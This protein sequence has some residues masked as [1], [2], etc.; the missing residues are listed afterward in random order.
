MN[1]PLIPASEEVAAK[2]HADRLL[3]TAF[4]D[5]S[6]LPRHGAAPPVPQPGRPPMSQGATDASAL[7][8]S[9]SV[10]TA[11][12]GGSATAILWASGHADPAVVATVF[13]APAIFALA[14]ARVL[15]RAKD[16]APDQHHHHY[17]GP[18]Y[19]DQRTQQ[20]STRGLIA[21]THNTQ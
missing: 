7:M 9:G 8:L 19:Q 2:E 18:V 3:A 4:R 10:L 11:T 16:A 15:K 5:D 13:G 21:R 20:T 12:L 14:I 17:S 6:P 1:E